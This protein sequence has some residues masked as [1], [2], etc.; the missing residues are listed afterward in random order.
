[1]NFNHSIVD[2]CL[3]LSPVLDSTFLVGKKKMC[4]RLSRVS[5]TIPTRGPHWNSSSV[6]LTGRI[7]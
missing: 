6:M 7:N 3:C 4:P 5:P 1:M 2:F